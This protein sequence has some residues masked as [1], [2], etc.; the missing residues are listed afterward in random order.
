MCGFIC[1]FYFDGEIKD[2][3]ILRLKGLNELI[4]HRGPDDEGFY[5]SFDKKLFFSHRRLSILDLSEKGH[6]PMESEDGRYVIVFNGEIY[7][8][9]ELRDKLKGKYEFFSNCDTEVLLKLYIEYG[10]N[11][12]DLID[13]MYSFAIWDNLKKELFVSRDILG[14]KPLYYFLESKRI[15]FSSEIKPLLELK[16]KRNLSRNGIFSYL[17][18]G[19]VVG[20][21]SIFEGIKKF[22][23]SS[24]LKMDMN[25]SGNL[26]FKNY[27]LG[28]NFKRDEGLK[29]LV[30]R[31]V[32]RRLIS[33]VRLG[34]MLS[35][36]VD[37]SLVTA[38]LSKYKKDIDTYTVIF[39]KGN[40][41]YDESERVSFL[42]KRLGLK[43]KVISMNF[44]DFYK[45]FI[46]LIFQFEEPVNNPVW[47]SIYLISKFSR[48]DGSKVLLSGDG[49]DEIFFGYDRWLLYY[50]ILLFYKVFRFLPDGNLHREFKFRERN[51][52]PLFTGKVNFRFFELEST[53]NEEFF[54]IDYLKEFY[55]REKR[56][57]KKLFESERT[58]QWMSYISIRTNFVEDFLMRNDKMGMLNSVEIRSPLLNRDIFFKGLSLK[59]NER[60]N[61]K[62]GK[63]SLKKLLEDETGNTYAN[64]KKVG[65][66]APVNMWM[67]EFLREN[68]I[69]ELYKINIREKIFKEEFLKDLEKNPRGLTPFKIFS[70]FIFT[71]W[72]QKWMEK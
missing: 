68:W 23:P 56:V 49:G 34:V 33:D 18:Y 30:E 66:C 41:K 36:G 46:D 70:L 50:K 42:T 26:E 67:D 40:E 10:E 69:Y 53:L 57:F 65:F 28:I 11:I 44:S 72:Y 54:R 6:Q 2:D 3:E 39:L 55:S 5:I 29:E 4:K 8:F 38:Y 13:G 51:E 59:R 45:N 24:Y 7:N 1:A 14:Q 47:T 31:S 21:N 17:L 15:V 12:F 62:R 16:G 20:E 22:P 32:K 63:I 43:N 48:E 25:F 60:F 61:F 37:S 71:K 52:V 9:L 64:L 58:D 35:G 27:L 19:S